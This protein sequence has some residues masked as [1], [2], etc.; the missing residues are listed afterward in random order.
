MIL[1][2]QDLSPHVFPT[3]I[4]NT[5]RETILISNKA[6]QG[7]YYTIV[8][9]RRTFKKSFQ[10]SITSNQ[11]LYQHNLKTRPICLQ[12]PQSA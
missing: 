2:E 8:D 7:I 3:L 5:S 6:R 1:R 11:F 4:G 10:V 12:F 9:V